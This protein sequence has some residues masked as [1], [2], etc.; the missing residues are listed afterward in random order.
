ME[1]PI[2]EDKLNKWILLGLLFCPTALLA[3]PASRIIALSP[4]AVEMLYAIGAGESIVAT[5]DHADYPE[6]AQF[7]ERVGG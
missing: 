2:S 6:E 1:P 3:Q 4:H 5:T 7:I